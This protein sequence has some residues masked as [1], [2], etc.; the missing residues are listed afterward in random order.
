MTYVSVKNDSFHIDYD[1]RPV[2]GQFT[3]PIHY[4]RLYEIYFLT[5]GSCVYFIND[6]SYRME[7]GDL[8][9]IPEGVVHHSF[10]NNTGH[11]RMLINCARRFIPAKAIPKGHLYR[12]PAIT[13]ELRG[14]FDRIL[15][16]Y[17]NP[18]AFSEDVISCSM[19]LL[20]F[21]LARTP[22]LYAADGEGHGAV[23][24]AI[25]HL[26]HHFHEELSLAEVAEQLAVSPE[27]LS[28]TFKKETGVG[29]LSFV[30]LL[31]LQKAER[32]LKESPELSV[33]EVAVRCGFSDSNYFSV[34]FKQMYGV[35]PKAF[36]RTR[37]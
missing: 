26:T 2:D 10:Y 27:H 28:R 6:R 23:A 29:F 24:K 12:N 13:G 19:Q 11:S 16:E 3:N 32:L 4:H 18:D 15:A 36:Q 37:K 25:T 34:K 21:L 35:S 20:F 5:E 9:L 1:V 33:A 14:I 22:N 17:T 8:A 31:R 7:A 30:N